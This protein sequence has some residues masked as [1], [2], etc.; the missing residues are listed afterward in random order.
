MTPQNCSYAENVMVINFIGDVNSSPGENCAPVEI[1]SSL[2][3]SPIPQA[4]D[5][6]SRASVVSEKVDELL[7]PAE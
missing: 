6:S 3:R 7:D 1:D 5:L 4:G 2:L